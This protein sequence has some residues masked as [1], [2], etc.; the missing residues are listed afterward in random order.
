MLLNRKVMHSLV[1]LP[2]QLAV[3]RMQV[4]SQLAPHRLKALSLL[5]P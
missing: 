1:T 2:T 4:R 3:P 5:T